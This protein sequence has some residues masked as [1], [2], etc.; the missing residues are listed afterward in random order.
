MPIINAIFYQFA[1]MIDHFMHLMLCFQL[2]KYAVSNKGLMLHMQ[3]LGRVIY[4]HISKL[5]LL[6][7]L[8]SYHIEFFDNFK[9]SITQT[10]DRGTWWLNKYT[11]LSVLNNVYLSQSEYFVNLLGYNDSKLIEL[12]SETM[13]HGK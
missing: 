11:R 13:T 9:L 3:W 2:N 7:A 4:C 1:D 6:S 12:L 5:V 8:I 10:K